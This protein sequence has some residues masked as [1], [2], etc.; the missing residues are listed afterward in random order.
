M[1][2]LVVQGS[3]DMMEGGV[4]Q[5]VERLSIGDWSL[6][7]GEEGELVIKNDDIVRVR[8][9]NNINLSTNLRYDRYF[10]IQPINV[11]DC[12]GMFVSATPRI[13]NFDMSQVPSKNLALPAIEISKKA[14]DP[15]VM[16][17]LVGCEN[18]S[19]RLSI[20]NIES[21]H[22]QEDDL[23]R[24]FVHSGHGTGS[25]WVTDINGP[26]KRGDYITTSNIAGYGMKQDDDVKHPWTGPR[27][28]TNCNFHPKTIVLEKPVDFDED[29]PIYE[30]I[31]NMEGDPITDMEYTMKYIHK[32]GE[33]A[34][35]RE[36]NEDIESLSKG[37]KHEISH[38]LKSSK[39][40]IY[41]ACLI[42]YC[43]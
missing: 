40:T 27:S 19:R 21:E 29:G 14:K 33:I 7:V 16:G 15:T 35:V 34:T 2:G 6:E 17:I 11:D 23:N 1:K 26:I 36:F 32:D 31:L 18:Y 25:V 3:I 39:R 43:Y 28:M 22:P 41:K 20:G 9:T 12:I 8:L 10:M 13:Y 5:N 37:G 30:S 24:V 42:A 38:I 4:I